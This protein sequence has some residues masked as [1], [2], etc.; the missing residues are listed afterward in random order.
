MMLNFLLMFGNPMFLCLVPGLCRAVLFLA[1]SYDAVLAQRIKPLHRVV[2]VHL[3]KIS[4]QSGQLYNTSYQVEVFVGIYYI[5]LLLT[6]A[7]NF[8]I[9]LFYWQFLRMRYIQSYGIR[10]AFQN[11]RGSIDQIFYHPRCPA[12][13]RSVWQ[14][15]VNFLYSICRIL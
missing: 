1:Q 14:K 13:L 5:F 9:L 3:R 11:I 6:P 7:R 12:M 15:I 8:L 10:V 4:S 2:A